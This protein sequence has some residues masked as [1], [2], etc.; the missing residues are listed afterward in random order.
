V[1]PGSPTLQSERASLARAVLQE[2]LRHARGTH[3]ARAAGLAFFTALFVGLGVVGGDPAWHTDLRA[4]GSYF[5]LSIGI[6]ITARASDRAGAWLR[7]APALVDMPFVFIVQRSQY[8]TTPS[9]AAVA[10]FTLGIFMLLLVLASLAG[11]TAQIFGAAMIASVFEVWLQRD[12]QV[13]VGAQVSAV[14][15]LLL[16]AALLSQGTRRLES[17]SG[18]AARTEKLAAL[19]QLSAGIGHELRNPLAVIGSAMFVLRRRLVKA[20]ALT[21]AVAEPLE[22]VEREVQAS[23]RI[24]TELLDFA[25][26]T[27]VTPEPIAFGPLLAECL[28]LLR[29]PPG[30]T[31]TSNLPAGLPHPLGSRDKLRQVLVNLLQN[32]AEAIPEGRAGTV[33]VRAQPEGTA[34]VIAVRDDGAG[35]DSETQR[36]IFE[37]LF[38]TKSQGT[39]LGLAIVESLVKQHGGS[40]AVDSAPGAGST[41]TVRLPSW[42]ASA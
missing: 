41:F 17:L 34:F 3:A 29:L 22:L 6:F 7:L 20:Q 15:L 40:L 39:G 13:S 26:Q 23:Q 19:G 36:R 16:A 35:M 38:T 27:E 33:E 25:R 21:A 11:G 9:P 28:G 2:H 24:V 31:V 4:L 1:K 18:T 8:A 14:V 5:A 32:A 10:G 37:P 12:A 30:V 42:V